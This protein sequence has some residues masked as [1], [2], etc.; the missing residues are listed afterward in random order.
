MIR[1]HLAG[2][3]GVSSAV[4]LWALAPGIS[5]GTAM[6]EPSLTNPLQ[7]LSGPTQPLDLEGLRGISIKTQRLR[8]LME[9]HSRMPLRRCMGRVL[10]TRAPGEAPRGGQKSSPSC[11][12][13]RSA[14]PHHLD[15]PREEERFFIL[16]QLGTLRGETR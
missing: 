7:G 5:V 11:V 14:E 6:T 15:R 9:E 3:H 10:R 12:T 13:A 4:G 8:R 16:N 2:G 1:R